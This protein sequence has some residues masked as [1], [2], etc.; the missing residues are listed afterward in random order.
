[1]QESD[2]ELGNTGA[3]GLASVETLDDAA[4]EKVAATGEDGMETVR[5]DGDAN[6]GAVPPKP[7][8]LV[9]W[10]HIAWRNLFVTGKIQSYSNDSKTSIL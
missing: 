8:M 2:P 7:N 10:I 3:V 9:A 6:D 1:M 4:G 5:L